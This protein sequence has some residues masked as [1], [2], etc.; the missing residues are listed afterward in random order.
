MLVMLAMLALACH[1]A[2]AKADPVLASE[3]DEELATQLANPLADLI[4]IPFQGSY[5]QGAVVRQNE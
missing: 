4:S 5:N 3:D 1:V 2:E